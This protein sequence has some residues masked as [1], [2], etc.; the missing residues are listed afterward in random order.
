MGGVRVRRRWALP[1]TA[2]AVVAAAAGAAAAAVAVA[3][4]ALTVRGAC[5]AGS[6]APE[7][8]PPLSVADLA[9]A[10]TGDTG[11]GAGDGDP[12]ATCGGRLAGTRHTV[13]CVGGYPV[14]GYVL[15]PPRPPSRAL[16]FLH[17]LSD[18]PAPVHLA[19]LAR[20]LGGRDGG[21]RPPP[22]SDPGNRR[23][24]NDDDDDDDGDATDDDWATVRVLLP[25]APRLPRLYVPPAADL[26][27]PTGA[28]HAWFDISHTLAFQ[29]VGALRG[30]APADVAASLVATGVVGDRAGLA[31]SA[32]RVAEL[33]AAQAAG[34]LG[35]GGLAAVAAHHTAVVGHSLGAAF[36]WHLAVAAREV[37]WTGAVALSGYLPLTAY[38][39]RFPEVVP[40]PGPP[41]RSG[42]PPATLVS[43]AADGD[44]V[45]A[46][47]L[48]AAA[49]ATGS[50]LAPRTGVR[51]VHVVLWGSD[52]ASYLLG[53]DNTDVVRRLLLDAL[54]GG[55]GGGVGG[56]GGATPRGGT[57]TPAMSRV[58]DLLEGREGGAGGVCH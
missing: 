9:A 32:C 54:W 16:L 56:E 43:V 30:D 44:T 14:G 53:D 21:R 29:A 22:P 25:L 28:V 34:R 6:V 39:A 47:A 23:R 52:H 35:G 50:A 4:I 20:L 3:A 46:P 27:L 24:V 57:S 37:P 18:A 17:G 51:V 31:A 40:P 41:R 45:V 12:V 26:G 2:P 11:G 13:V 58:G 42:R 15:E 55:E 48:S 49:A 1:T 8:Q 7:Q 33:V 19:V 38:Y 5:A 10:A 36:A